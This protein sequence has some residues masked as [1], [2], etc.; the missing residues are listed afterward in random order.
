MSVPRESANKKMLILL[1]CNPL[2]ALTTSRSLGELDPR[3]QRR[4]TKPIFIGDS[5]SPERVSN[6]YLLGAV[7]AREC[8][9]RVLDQ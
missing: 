6:F 4:N 8:I 1:S 9:L 5:L 2:P 3:A 7:Y